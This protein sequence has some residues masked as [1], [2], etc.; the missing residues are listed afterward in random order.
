MTDAEERIAAKLD[1]VA[2]LLALSLTRD[3]KTGEKI[4]LL[5]KAGMDRV[6][7]AQI[8]ETTPETVSVRMAEAKRK[9]RAKPSVHETVDPLA[10]TS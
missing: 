4:L 9:A 10:E 5:S 8:A 1:V 2:R 6:T 7:I 3:L